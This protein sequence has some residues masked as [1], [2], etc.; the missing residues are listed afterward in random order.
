MECP[1]EPPP[2]PPPPLLKEALDGGGGGGSRELPVVAPMTEA[3]RDV[4]ENEHVEERPPTPE[5]EVLLRAEET[6][7]LRMGGEER[8]ETEVLLH[9]EEVVVV[10]KGCRRPLSVRRWDGGVGSSRPAETR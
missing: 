8:V 9:P 1:N 4:D 3:E 2:P 7:P 10:E 6:T 5:E